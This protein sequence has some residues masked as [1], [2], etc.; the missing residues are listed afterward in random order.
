MALVVGFVASLVTLAPTV[1]ITWRRA[2]PLLWVQ[3]SLGVFE[4]L[5]ASRW[6]PRS[7]GATPPTP[8]PE[9]LPQ[10]VRQ[11]DND[12]DVVRQQLLQA[13]ADSTRL[14]GERDG[15]LADSTRLRGER[16]A[17]LADSTRLRGERDGALAD[18]TR[19]RGE[20]DAALA[21]STRLRDE[22]DAALADSTQLR[23]ALD[24]AEGRLRALEANPVA[25]T[26]AWSFRDV[27]LRLEQRPP[28][29]VPVGSVVTVS[30]S[31]DGG[32]VVGSL[33]SVIGW[34][35]TGCGAVEISPS[36]GDVFQFEARVSGYCQVVATYLPQITPPETRTFRV[37]VG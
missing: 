37:R 8:D 17:A 25:A 2:L 33:S 20:R 36:V 28:G 6:V 29:V 19:L 9:A 7:L 18:S 15:A 30:V 4:A 3:P 34:A 14:R 35:V 5:A 24:S 16:D 11:R 12:L 32:L 13:L 31:Y 10:E 22:R 27:S 23:E 21:D 26:W 1:G